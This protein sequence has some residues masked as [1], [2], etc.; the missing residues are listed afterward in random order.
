MHNFSDHMC[1]DSPRH[2]AE[3]GQITVYKLNESEC[4]HVDHFCPSADLWIKLGA[5]HLGE[6][7]CEESHLANFQAYMPECQLNLSPTLTQEGGKLCSF[8]TFLRPANMSAERRRECFTAYDPD[9]KGDRRDEYALTSNR[10]AWAD[11]CIKML[12]WFYQAAKE[13]T[14]DEGLAVLGCSLTLFA[15]DLVDYMRKSADENGLVFDAHFVFDCACFSLSLEEDPVWNNY[16]DPACLDF[17][18]QHLYTPFANAA[19]AHFA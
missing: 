15:E 3:G 4:V 1:Y 8:H 12:Y 13:H 17:M 5:R 11:K 14:G 6:M 18:R 2:D 16:D 19:R 7:L 9:F 10:E